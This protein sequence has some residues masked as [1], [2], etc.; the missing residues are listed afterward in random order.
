M[1]TLEDLKEKVDD[2]NAEIRQLEMKRELLL[3]MIALESNDNAA[4]IKHTA[5]AVDYGY[6]GD[7]SFVGA[8]ISAGL[9]GM[10][11]DYDLGK[12]YLE[13]F[14]NDYKLSMLQDIPSSSICN[15]S[16]NLAAAECHI[17]DRD[18]KKL[19]PE[20]LSKILDY[21]KELIEVAELA[22]ELTEEVVHEVYQVGI[23]LYSG[24]FE[25]PM[26][27]KV[28]FTPDKEYGIRALKRAAD[29]GSL[30]AKEFLESEGIT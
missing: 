22:E 13:K 25:S 2:I 12:H 5:K 15:V 10:A 18:G 4:A 24:N 23:I 30:K 3:S 19:T 1:G 20:V 28:S 7:Y 6:R 9:Y 16:F 27:N 17:C 29:L 21:Y 14:Y 8:A 26:H 11:P